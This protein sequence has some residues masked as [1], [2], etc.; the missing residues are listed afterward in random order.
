MLISIL[1]PTF[2]RSNLL[3]ILYESLNRQS[4]KDFEWIIVDDGSNDDTKDVVHKFISE[5]VISINYIQKEWWK[6]YSY[7]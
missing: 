1:T 4:F 7:K 3:N 5:N 2:N 6:T